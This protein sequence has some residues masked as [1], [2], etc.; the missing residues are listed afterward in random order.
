[1]AKNAWGYANHANSANRAAFTKKNKYLQFSEIS[2][3]GAK[4]SRISANQMEMCSVNTGWYANP[5]NSA[6]RT[7]LVRK[8]KYLQMYTISRLGARVSR[9][10]AQRG[11]HNAVRLQ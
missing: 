4:V 8:N 1:M 10:S 5:A 2:R 9:I 7:G 3:W 6:N 11:E